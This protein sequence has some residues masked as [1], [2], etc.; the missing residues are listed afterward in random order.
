MISHSCFLLSL[1][2]GDFL[3]RNM[4][5][6]IINVS[7]KTGLADEDVWRSP[8]RIWY[9]WYSLWS[10]H[11]YGSWRQGR[12]FGCGNVYLIVDVCC[13][14]RNKK[15][16]I[17]K[18]K[19]VKLNIEFIFIDWNISTKSVIKLKKWIGFKRCYLMIIWISVSITSYYIIERNAS[20][21]GIRTS[22]IG[23]A[24]IGVQRN[25]NFQKLTIWKSKL[26]S[27]CV[28]YITDSS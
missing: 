23:V 20:G 24:N 12:L 28:S 13:D 25:H 10:L 3:T 14:N 7:H 17:L 15:M 5:H 8:T 4:I 22:N 16:I 18:I 1:Y 2:F 11:T 27:K 26:L 6:K 19:E 21:K 9:L